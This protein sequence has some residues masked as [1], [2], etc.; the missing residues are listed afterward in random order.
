MPQNFRVKLRAA[1]VPAV[2]FVL[3]S[4][5]TP[6]SFLGVEPY[7]ME[8]QQ[9]NYVARDAIARLKPG[10]TREQVRFLLG[11]PLIADVFHANRWDYVFYRERSDG[12]REEARLAVFFEDGQLKQ[13]TGDGMPGVA[14]S[15]GPNS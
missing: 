7:R 5:G 2:A 13:V 14:A 15:A 3:G 4:C 9:G 12:R 10:M 11:T 8:I 1:L 6:H